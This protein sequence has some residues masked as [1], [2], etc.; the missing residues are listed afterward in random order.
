MV[1]N[2]QAQEEQKDDE[3]DFEEVEEL[4]AAF[5][6]FDKNGDNTISTKELK[7]V[8]LAMGQEYTQDQIANMVAEVDVDGDGVIDFSEFLSLMR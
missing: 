2:P 8:M 3:L 5:R 7:H 4:K 6:L 1:E